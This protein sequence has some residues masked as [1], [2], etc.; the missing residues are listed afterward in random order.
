[1]KILTS[2][3]ALVFYF[4]A[5][6][7]TYATQD[8]VI[9]TDVGV[10]DA[11]AMAYF[12]KQP[13]IQIKAITIEADGNASC[14]PAYHNVLN[15]LKLLHHPSI[16][17]ACGSA[18]PLCE[19]HR[20]PLKLRKFENTFADSIFQASNLNPPKLSAPELLV[21]VLRAAKQPI[22]ILAIG[23][24]TNLAHVFKQNPVLKKKIR[25]I[26][27]MGGAVHVPGNIA[28]VYPGKSNV[29]EWNIYFDPC[30]AKEVFASG[31]P[32]TLVPLDITNKV[33]ITRKFYNEIKQ[34]HKTPAAKFVFELLHLNKEMLFHHEWYFWDPMAAVIALNSSLAVC[35][36][37]KLNVILTPARLSG[38]TVVDNKNGHVIQVCLSIESEQF[39]NVL[40]DGLNH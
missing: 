2:C 26:Y 32:I 18:V 11:I 8:F 6:N 34:Q 31:V 13:T 28:S 15:I 22:N 9:D 12:I 38:Q 14:V 29:A 36:P 20:F 17:V 1:M 30:A 21:S 24:L 33:Q 23:P 37:L 39:K 35:K 16:P 3:M 40:L 7:L 19:D 25:M 27:L 10:D 5:C 4:L